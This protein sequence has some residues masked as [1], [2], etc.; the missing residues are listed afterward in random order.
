MQDMQDSVNFREQNEKF[1]PFWKDDFSVLYNR[2]R[3]TEFIPTID[4]SVSERL[5]AIVRFAVYTGVLMGLIK[6]EIWPLYITIFGFAV[7]LFIETNRDKSSEQLLGFSDE[8]CTM[9]T[10]ENP[11]MNPLQFENAEDKPQAC[12]LEAAF[13]E[14]SVGDI[15]DEKFYKG[16]Y[17]DSFDLFERNNSQ[18]E[19][20]TTPGAPRH[21]T[22]EARHNFAMALYGNAP[23]CRSDPFDCVPYERLQQKRPIFPNPNVNPVT[24]RNRLEDLPL[25]DQF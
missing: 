15:V 17:Q 6:N 23:S 19:F 7:T 11:F 24:E 9:P 10:D 21:P 1:D 13:G 18:R 20:Y 4:M 5:N 22:A 16:L 2:D 8:V 14:H 25:G 12:N 3:L